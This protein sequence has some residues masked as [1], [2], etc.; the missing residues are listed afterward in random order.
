MDGA[1]YINLWQNS[2][3]LSKNVII[4]C[5]FLKIIIVLDKTIHKAFRIHKPL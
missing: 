3:G 2:Q 5:K 4:F 1:L